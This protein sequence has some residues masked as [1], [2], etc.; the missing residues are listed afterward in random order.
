MELLPSEKVVY[1]DEQTGRTVWQMTG[2]PG[3][4]AERCKN[5]SCYQEVEGFTADGKYLLFTSD[6][7]GC[8]QLYRA[9]L[10]S[11]E[12]ARLTDVLD[13]SAFSFAIGPDARTA[14]FFAGCRVCSVDV[15]TGEQTVVMDFEGEILGTIPDAPP[16]F[17]GNGDCLVLQFEIAEGVRAATVGCLATGAHTQVF[18]WQGK[19]NHPQICPGDDDLITFVPGPDTQN[20]MSLP[21]EKRART[22]VWDGKSGETRPFLTMPKGYRATHEYW[23]HA[24]DRFYYHRKT[25]P[26]GGPTA[27]ASVDRDGGDGRIHWEHARKLGHSSIDRTSTFIVSDVQVDGENELF[28]TD[29]ETGK[30]EILC[31]PNTRSVYDQTSHVHPSIS[32]GGNFIDFTSDRCGP[33]DVYVYPLEQI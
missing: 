26:S 7:T 20:D 29:G 14:F 5:V 15:E 8:F 12:I 33:S 31:W 28:L 21:Q 17:S 13:L 6:R 10:F 11:G 4:E 3:S 16:S 2:R 32:A 1:T 24:G 9:E 19:M 27:V 30:A 18:R 22:W 25:V 23:D